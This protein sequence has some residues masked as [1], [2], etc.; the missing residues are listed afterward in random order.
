M[1]GGSIILFSIFMNMIGFSIIKGIK[2]FVKV[3]FMRI[4]LPLGEIF[5][6]HSTLVL[7]YVTY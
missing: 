6:Y 3:I 5:K 4:A 7:F 1:G 2:R